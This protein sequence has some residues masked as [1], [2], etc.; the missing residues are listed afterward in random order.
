MTLRYLPLSNAES[1]QY[2]TGHTATSDTAP[3]QSQV[4]YE[5]YT[6]S[7]HRSHIIIQHRQRS[8]A[9]QRATFSPAKTIATTRAPNRPST[10]TPCKAQLTLQEQ[11]ELP[12]WLGSH[13]FAL[14]GVGSITSRPLVMKVLLLHLVGLT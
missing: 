1:V 8:L 14:G 6:A 10:R 7:E 12:C 11:A 13:D 9:Q 4:L 2:Y 5:G 3:R